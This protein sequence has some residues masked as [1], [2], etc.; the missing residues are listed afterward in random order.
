MVIDVS[1]STMARFAKQLSLLSG[2][3]VIDNT[4]LK[5]QFN[6]HLEYTPDPRHARPGLPSHARARWRQ[7]GQFQQ[8]T[9]AP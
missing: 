7:S 6:F 8:P 4:G 1:G 9:T 2:R 3:P 5:G